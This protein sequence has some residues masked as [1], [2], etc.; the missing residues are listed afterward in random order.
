MSNGIFFV[1]F[2]TKLSA[3]E[4]A[5]YKQFYPT[6]LLLASINQTNGERRVACS[7]IGNNKQVSLLDALKERFGFKAPARLIQ[8]VAKSGWRL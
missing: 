2:A 5:V 1:R 8:T 4:A 6:D 7:W 3:E